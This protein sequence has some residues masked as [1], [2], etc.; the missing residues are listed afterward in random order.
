[1]PRYLVNK[2]S[3]EII[4]PRDPLGLVPDCNVIA[5]LYETRRRQRI[6]FNPDSW[7]VERCVDDHDAFELARTRKY[8]E[9]VQREISMKFTQ[10]LRER[11]PP[12]P[13]VRPID[14]TALIQP[15]EL[16]EQTP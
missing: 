5:E 12:Q 8:I 1:M 14:P 10:L 7:T 15:F 6:H 3:G 11:F 9:E 13:P 2:Y 4:C 16:W